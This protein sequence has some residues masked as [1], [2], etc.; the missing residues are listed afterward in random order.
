[1]SVC[2]KYKQQN[3]LSQGGL[4]NTGRDARVKEDYGR[5]FAERI[6]TGLVG[7]FWYGPTSWVG[8]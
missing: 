8:T 6:T 3:A 4:N 7:T 5:T 1:M 2:H